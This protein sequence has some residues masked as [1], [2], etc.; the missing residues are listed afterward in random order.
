[1]SPAGE[2]LKGSHPPSQLTRRG[3]E[4]LRLGVGESLQ[5]LAQGG[6]RVLR[7][8]SE[9]CGK[10][11]Q[12]A[13]LG[14]EVRESAMACEGFDAAE[15]GADRRIRSAGGR[16]RPE[17][18]GRCGCRRKVIGRSR[19]CR[20]CGPARPGGFGLGRVSEVDLFTRQV[21][22]PAVRLEAGSRTAAIG[23]CCA[24]TARRSE[25]RSRCCGS[26]GSAPQAMPSQLPCSV[27]TA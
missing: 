25:C 4:E 10:F 5:A 20:R 11:A 13:A 22:V 26:A 2:C 21:E 9:E 24:R 14:V 18:N 12:E 7:A 23:G 1:M 16:R 8:G 3:R 17:S 27:V 19:R 6:R 15:V